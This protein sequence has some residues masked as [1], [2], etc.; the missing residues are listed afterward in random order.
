MNVIE[1]S[2]LD[3]RPG[4]RPSSGAAATAPAGS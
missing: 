4:T 2:G 1:A 3:K